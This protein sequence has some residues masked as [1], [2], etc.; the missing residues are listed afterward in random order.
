MGNYLT[1]IAIV[2]PALNPCERMVELVREC[3]DAG[4]ENII[5][6]DDGSSIENRIYFK[7]CKEKYNC[8]ILRHV[9]NFGKGMA[10]KSA[11]NHILENRPDI[12]GTVTVDCDGQHVV[13]DIITCAKLVCEHPD[14]LILGCRQFDDP[15]IPWRSRFGNKMTCRIIKLL[16]GIS[17]SDTQTACPVNFSP[18]ILPPQRASALNTR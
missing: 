7:T 16:C 17:I 4:F 3:K 5:L 12:I 15:K 9:V 10:L 11:F 2:I 18:I 1:D 6:V 14:R 13:K 8:R